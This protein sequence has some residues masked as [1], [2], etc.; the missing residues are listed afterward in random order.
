VQPSVRRALK[1]SARGDTTEPR[2][3]RAADVI[4][5][6]LLSDCS[7]E[8]AD[9]R[10]LVDMAASTGALFFDI[11]RSSRILAELMPNIMADSSRALAVARVLAELTR[12]SNNTCSRVTQTLLVAS[13]LR[14]QRRLT[15]AAGK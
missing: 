7:P 6:A 1:V 10:L 4:R 14:A 11:E 3:S 12:L 5:R 2:L 8:G 9:E 15:K 13:S